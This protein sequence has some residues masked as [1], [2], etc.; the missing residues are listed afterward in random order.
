MSAIAESFIVAEDKLAALTDVVGRGQGSAGADGWFTFLSRESDE[1]RSYRGS[2]YV[3]ASVLSY[4]DENGIALMNSAE[5]EV[6][7]R[8]SDA[9]GGTFVVM[10]PEHKR[11]FLDQLEPS[12]FAAA[13]MRAYYESLNGAP[14]NGADEAMLEGIRFLHDT[15]SDLTDGKVAVLAIV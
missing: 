4:L 13:D 5:Y 8:L 6:A 10:T 3:L 11:L 1:R 15:L 7:D 2:G 12:S 9:T 14:A